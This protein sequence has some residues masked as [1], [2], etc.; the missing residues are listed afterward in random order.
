MPDFGIDLEKY[1]F[2]T[3]VSANY[4]QNDIN[5]QIIKYVMSN[6]DSSVN[7]YSKVNFFERPNNYSFG[8]VVD[9]YIEDYLVTSYAF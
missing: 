3:N 8:C 1:V 5:M 6:T 2:E 9:I 4:I 7:I